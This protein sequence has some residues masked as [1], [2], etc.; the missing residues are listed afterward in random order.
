MALAAIQAQPVRDCRNEPIN[1]ISVP[2]ICPSLNPGLHGDSQAA[3]TESMGCGPRASHPTSS[4]AV[5][6]LS[7]F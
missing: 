7:G 4:I 2:D 5:R 1:L 6:K 3:Y